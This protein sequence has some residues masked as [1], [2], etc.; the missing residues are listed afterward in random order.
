MS[1]IGTGYDLS[2]S[3]FSPDGRVFQV[4]YFAALHKSCA[5]E[6]SWRTYYM[7]F[8]C[9]ALMMPLNAHAIYKKLGTFR[10]WSKCWHLTVNEITFRDEKFYSM[11]SL[12]ICT[13]FLERGLN[14][15]Y[16]GIVKRQENPPIALVL[17]SDIKIYLLKGQF[18]EICCFRFF[19]VSSSHKPLSIPL[20]P[21][22]FFS[23]IR[24]DIGKSR[25]TTSTS[26]TGGM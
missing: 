5:C 21:F 15:L 12:G 24:R 6:I 22:Q 7:I 18:H 3:Q 1:S 26:D 17:R 2:A 23:K 16:R 9:C 10:S 8:L 20:G 14:Q 4:I 25:C 19:H 13:K 11:A